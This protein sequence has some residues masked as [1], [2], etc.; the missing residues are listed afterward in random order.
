MN[1]LIEQVNKLLD[2]LKRLV[3]LKNKQTAAS[4]KLYRFAKDCLGVDASPFDVAPDEFG[5]AE[6]I[7]GIVR[8]AF[9]EPVGGGVS[10]IGLYYALK[11]SRYFAEVKNPLP[12][13]IIISPTSFGNGKIKN[14][15][16]G[17]VAPMNHIMSNS[18]ST[19]KFELNYSI[20]SWTERYGKEGGFPILFY[21][22]IY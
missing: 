6:T 8:M 12:G 21:R 20:K 22:R 11:Q 18:S 16:T 4:E 14:G 2:E 3:V 17:I 9:G 7:N 19:G 13:D 1:K 10:T 15:H 5:C